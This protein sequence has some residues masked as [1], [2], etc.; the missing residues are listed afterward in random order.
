M[1]GDILW[2]VFWGASNTCLSS[3]ICHTRL[4][5]AAPYLWKSP[6]LALMSPLEGGDNPVDVMYPI[7]GAQ[8][9]MK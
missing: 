4:S 5:T 6:P 2:T 3:D 1:L 9:R 7:L 8:T